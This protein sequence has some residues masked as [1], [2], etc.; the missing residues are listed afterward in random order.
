MNWKAIK[1]AWL[2]SSVFVFLCIW[3]DNGQKM[4]QFVAIASFL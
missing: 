4:A 3:V 2:Y 1:T